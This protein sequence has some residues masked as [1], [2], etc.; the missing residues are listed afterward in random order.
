[1]TLAAPA[2]PGAVLTASGWNALQVAFREALAAHR[3]V[4][5]EGARLEGEGLDAGGTLEVALLDLSESI[6]IGGDDLDKW[7][8]KSRDDM[9]LRLAPDLAR[10]L[11][12]S[13]GTVL[14][15]LEV[16]GAT[17]RGQAR[18]GGRLIVRG[19][20]RGGPR[21]A[22]LLFAGAAGL[23]FQTEARALLLTLAGP[24]DA[25]AQ[26]ALSGPG[27]ETSLFTP[28]LGLRWESV[29]GASAGGAPRDRVAVELSAGSWW[30][31]W[32]SP[33]SAAL[34]ALLLPV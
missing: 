12:R 21:A 1:M 17:S 3:H 8:L 7:I 9:F 32:S 15:G 33:C 11:P 24:L 27:G 28:S 2:V 16:G 5:G 20:V 22:R 31:R 13:G 4:G 10:K 25:A 6:E 19:A 34:A 14:G 18:V 26:L 30:L 29:C 23:R